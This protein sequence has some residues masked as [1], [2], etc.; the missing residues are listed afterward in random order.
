MS[1]H[2][3]GTVYHKRFWTSTLEYYHVELANAEGVIIYHILMCRRSWEKVHQSS[4]RL[5]VILK[6]ISAH[7]ETI[8]NKVSCMFR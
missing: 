5:E 7:N 6:W 3:L 1:D 4:V 8:T 2:N